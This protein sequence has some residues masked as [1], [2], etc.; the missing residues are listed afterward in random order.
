MWIAL[1]VVAIGNIVSQGHY[2]IKNNKVVLYVGII[3]VILYVSLC[4]AL[5]PS[6]RSLT[7]PLVY[8]FNFYFTVILLLV[9]LWK[10]I[11]DKTAFF[12][13][14]KSV[15]LYLGISLSLMFLLLLIVNV[16][17]NAFLIFF[18]AIGYLIVY[19]TIAYMTGSG[20]ADYIY[21][22]IYGYLK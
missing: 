18:I 21:K 2:T 7:I 11:E 8:T 20:E 15:V 5:L 19:I 16:N 14:I 6:F 22:K 3:E 10:K 4:L 13:L 1:P 12:L 9:L 17:A